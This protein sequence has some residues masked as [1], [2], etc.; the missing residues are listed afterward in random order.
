[1]FTVMA[2]GNLSELVPPEPTLMFEKLGE[3]GAVMV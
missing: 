1:M 2:V 3:D